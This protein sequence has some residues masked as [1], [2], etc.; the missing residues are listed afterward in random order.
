MEGLATLEGNHSLDPAP[1]SAPG[2]HERRAVEGGAV[3]GSVIFFGVAP[4]LVAGWIP[5]AL[6]GWRFEPALLGFP[7]G[8]IAGGILVAIGSAVLIDCFRSSP[9]RA[10]DSSARRTHRV[11][12]RVWS[13]SLRPEPDVPRGCQHHPGPGHSARQRRAARI[14]G[15]GVAALPCLVLRLRGAD[16]PEAVRRV[17]SNL[18]DPSRALVAALEALGRDLLP[19][20][21]WGR[22]EQW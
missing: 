14:R 20:R 6:S 15:C 22:G 16:P 7:A 19:Q 1:G 9:S 18:P 2:G 4:G 11:S 3:I 21:S 17:L 10:R 8:R 12:G 13:V 5:Y